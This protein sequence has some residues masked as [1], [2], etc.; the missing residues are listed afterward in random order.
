MLLQINSKRTEL[1]SLNAEC[2]LMLSRS[3]Q[4]SFHIKK[5]ELDDSVLIRSYCRRREQNNSHVQGGHIFSSSL[6]YVPTRYTPDIFICVLFLLEHGEYIN[7]YYYS[8]SAIK[9]LLDVVK[10]GLS[11]YIRKLSLRQE[12]IDT[13]PEI[14]L[15]RT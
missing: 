8:M 15:G 3:R 11:L 14:V 2:I 5:C 9:Y 1:L 12:P 6:L 7:R 10:I 4:P 13:N